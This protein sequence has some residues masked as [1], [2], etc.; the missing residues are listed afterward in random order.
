MK[1]Q[2]LCVAAVALI[3]SAS[4]ASHDVPSL[5]GVSLLDD[6]KDTAAVAPV[7]PDETDAPEKKD[8]LADET[9]EEE[10]KWRRTWRRV[11]RC[12]N[13]PDFI[14]VLEDVDFEPPL[15]DADEDSSFDEDYDFDEDEEEY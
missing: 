2:F 13:G 11:W 15:A 6:A 9:E 3:Q 14:D 12:Q 1:L 5:R 4:V 8:E 7:K 10:N